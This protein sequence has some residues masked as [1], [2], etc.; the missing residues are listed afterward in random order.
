MD[1]NRLK[2][3]TYLQ[4]AEQIPLLSARGIVQVIVEHHRLSRFGSASTQLTSE[5]IQQARQQ[6]LEVLLEWDVLCNQADLEA[7]WQVLKELPLEALSAIRV[8]DVGAASLLQQRLP[9]M[10]LHLIVET[11]NHNFEALSGWCEQFGRQLQRLVLSNELPQPVL[12]EYCSKLPVQTELLALGRI[13]LFYSPR[14]LLKPVA[15][16]SSLASDWKVSSDELPL[17]Q[18]PVLE[19]QHGTFLF[20]YY[21]L[22]LLDQMQALQAAG[23]HALRYDLRFGRFDSAQEALFQFL[24]FPS[25]DTAAQVKQLWPS[26][27]TRG[28]FRA[29]RTDK[30]FQLLKNPHSEQRG[31]NL[32]AT[33]V[34]AVKGSHVTLMTK[35]QL[36]LG[37]Q[38]QFLTPE[39]RILEHTLST[40]QNTQGENHPHTSEH[41]L[42]ILPHI[43]YAVPKTL[44]FRQEKSK[45]T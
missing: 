10:P 43:K 20:H 32:V 30:P 34:E 4:A 35:A 9:G 11:G 29:N 16:E 19:N 40:I 22:F 41:G 17:H 38:L 28:F 2:A 13:L 44:V 12:S 3:V 42:W 8:Q 18:L 45:T 36:R 33:V 24:S 25:P 39:G 15:G 37:D 1:A 31:E 7:G 23:L 26:K 14:S 6:N 27:T 21:D 5:L